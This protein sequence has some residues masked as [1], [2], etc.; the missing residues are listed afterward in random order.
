[1]EE[2]QIGFLDHVAIRAKDIEVS[3]KWYEDVLGL[4]RYRL[5]EWGPFPLF[6][7][8]GRSGV[9]IFPANGS[10]PKIPISKNV[11]IDHFAFNVTS[12][13]F[14]LAR[15]RYEEM[16]IEYRFEDHHYFH[17]IYTRD[18]DGHEV[19]LTTIVVNEKEF[20]DP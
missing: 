13:N 19:E 11:R 10:D 18:P 7:L 5:K 20:Y 16:G 9:A 12:E 8:S 2:F 14:E 4:K 15:K 17:S 1:M 3:A 6:L